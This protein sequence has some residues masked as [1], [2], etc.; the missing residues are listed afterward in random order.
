MLRLVIDTNVFISSL[1]QRGYP[2]LVIDN[3]FKER[4]TFELCVSSELLNEYNDVLNRIK[5]FKYADYEIKSKILLSDIKKFGIKYSPSIKI[6]II[7]DE[8][9]NRLLEL[10]ETCKAQYLITGNTKHFS[11][12]K[13]KGTKIVSPKEFCEL[14]VI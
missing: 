3:I 1:L 5:F 10:A 6:D 4:K 8:A 14:Q 12:K 11:I 2:F 7:K 13:Y 9:D